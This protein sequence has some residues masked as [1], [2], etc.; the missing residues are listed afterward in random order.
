MTTLLDVS[1]LDV[2]FG[3][4]AHGICAVDG[5]SFTV[6]QGE[7]LG[8]VGESG[9][10]KSVAAMSLLRLVGKPGRI[11][12]GSIRLAG[13]EL[14]A[15]SEREMRDVRGRDIS[16][17]F[18]DP[19]T[20]LNPV[21]TI[22]RQLT[23]VLEEQGGLSPGRARRRAVELLGEVGLPAPAKRLGDY[24]HHF[25]GGMR[26]RVGIAIA[27]ACRPKLLIA[28]EPTTALDVTIQ[29]QILDLLRAL[30]AELGMGVLLIT[31]DLGV[32]AGMADRVAVMYGGRIVEHGPADAVFAHPGMPYTAGLLAATPRL[33]RPGGRLQ[34][35][36]GRPSVAAGPTVACRFSPR[37]LRADTICRRDAPVL[38]PVGAAHEAA[39]HF[40]AAA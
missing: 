30:Q 3:D 27:I 23:E 19:M 26:Q 32:V 22:G 2:R 9:S 40:A 25:S 34:P 29:A 36:P 20:S 17:V 35:I 28:D 37:C 16:I 15:L 5:I 6:G 4:D 10:G 11:A 7:T 13:R 21:L 39:C 1:G 24:P 38:R 12:G 18:Q 14:L 33:D 8:L 31:H